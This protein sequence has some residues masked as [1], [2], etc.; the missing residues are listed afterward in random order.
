MGFPFSFVIPNIFMEAFEFEALA[1]YP[2][3]AKYF[4]T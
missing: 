3:E 2:V 1:N 4:V